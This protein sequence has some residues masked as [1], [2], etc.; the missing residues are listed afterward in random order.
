MVVLEVLAVL[1]G[2]ATV[3]STVISAVI[4]AMRTVVVPS[5]QPVRITSAVFQLVRL[6]FDLHSRRVDDP[7]R[8][9]R[10]MSLYTPL[11]L[12]LLPVVWFTAVAAGYSLMFWGVGVRPFSTAYVVSGSSLLTLGFERPDGLVPLTLAFSE[13][14]LGVAVLALLLVTYLPAMYAAY[15]RREQAVLLLEVRAGAPPSGVELLCR[16][17]SI[18]GL[19]RLGPIWEE[20]EG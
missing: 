4:S 14:A 18:G 16:Y 20:W 12:L 19:D 2:V 8:R 10:E 6:A 1:A 17:A 9:H 7:D 11:S 5:A 13:A 15:S 3:I